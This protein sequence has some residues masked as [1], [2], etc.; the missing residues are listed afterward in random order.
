MPIR[1]LFRLIFP[2][3]LAAALL[4]C[5][6]EPPAASAPADPA[7]SAPAAQ[8]QAAEPVAEPGLTEDV[9]TFGQSAAFSGPAQALGTNMRIGIEA[10]FAEAN[11]RGGVHGRLL[12]LVSLDDRYEPEAAIAN[13]KRL[14]HDDHVFALIGAVGTPTSRSALPVA[15]AAGVPYLAPFTGAG[16]LRDASWGNIL[17]VRASYNQETEE[18][19][20][21]LTSDLGVERIAIV[22][23]DDSFGRAGLN[24]SLAALERRRMNPAA[25]ARYQRNTIHVKRTLLDLMQGQ[26]EAV[27]MVGAYEPLSELI[28]WTRHIGLDPV[29]I[30]ISFVGSMALAD[31]LQAKDARNGHGVYVTQVVPFPF[32][33]ISKVAEGYR[34]AL[35]ASGAGADPGFVSFE[36]YLAGRLAIAA[37]ENCGRD[38]TRDC[39]VNGLQGSG[40]VSLDG[41]ELLYGP[42]DNQG[43]DT[44]FLTVIG[45]DGRLHAVRTLRENF[46]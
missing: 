41:F 27:I 25:T 1:D 24:G 4:S 30:N 7:A 40:V 44:V 20:E 3:L 11:R 35:A 42:E 29:F 15:A 45:S 18:M 2:V 16:F 8:A 22:Y 19:V 9:I 43:S 34:L 13:T 6:S 32:S 21:R 39:L 5:R 12:E 10:A 23:Q 36:G 37:L 28:A 33:D 38:V 26:P 17:N 46:P 14:I 31:R